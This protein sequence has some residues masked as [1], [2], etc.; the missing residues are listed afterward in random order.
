MA[1][2]L[3]SSN[4]FLS[5]T[6]L[7]ISRQTINCHIPK[8]HIKLS[9]VVKSSNSLVPLPKREL[10]EIDNL[11]TV[12]KEEQEWSIDKSTLN[13]FI[14]V[15]RQMLVKTLSDDKKLLSPEERESV[16]SLSAALDAC[17]S[18]QFYSQLEDMKVNNLFIHNVYKTYISLLS[19]Y[20]I[21][22]LLFCYISLTLI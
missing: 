7:R 14:P 1:A 13:K 16:Q 15:T 8:R 3:R 20:I 4:T 2:L 19:N 6:S 21:I 10:E 12:S 11:L 17:I 9:S 22:F 18:Q 5:Y